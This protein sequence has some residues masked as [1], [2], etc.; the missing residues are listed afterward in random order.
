MPCGLEFIL[1]VQWSAL[2]RVSAHLLP[3]QLIANVRPMTQSADHSAHLSGDPLDRAIQLLGRAREE[4]ERA[5]GSAGVH[6]EDA[7]VEAEDMIDEQQA[8]IAA[9]RTADE[10]E[11]EAT[12]DADRRRSAW[13]PSYRAA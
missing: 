13:F 11:A 8:K 5:Q 9:A 7:L 3:D 6:L 1:V 2:F 10:D 4:L 12:G